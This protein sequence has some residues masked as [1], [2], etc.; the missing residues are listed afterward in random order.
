MRARDRS[1]RFWFSGARSVWVL[2]FALLLAAPSCG[3]S[4][5]ADTVTYDSSTKQENL[6]AQPTSSENSPAERAA[7]DWSGGSPTTT[8]ASSLFSD[9]YSGEWLASPADYSFPG[10]DGQSLTVYSGRN[11]S[12]IG[13]LLKLFE[14]V[15]GVDVSVRYGNSTDLAL[16][17]EAEGEASP[18]DLFISQ[19]PG[20]IEYLAARGSLTRL[21]DDL[22]ELVPSGMRSADGYWVGL[23]GRR[24]VLVYNTWLVSEE[25]LPES[26]F[27][28]TDPLYKKRVAV[29]PAN[30]SFQDFITLMRSSVG[31]ERALAWLEGMAKN[32]S[33]VYAK[34]S[35]IVDGVLR[36]EVDMGLVNHYYLLRYLDE[37]PGA[38]GANYYFPDDDL[39][40]TMLLTGV[41][42]LREI[43]EVSSAKRALLEF[44]L[45]DGSQGYYYANTREYPAREG[46]RRPSIL[47]PLPEQ[48][49]AFR[50]SELAEG[51]TGTLR[52]IELS[53]IG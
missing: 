39:G 30:S 26:V 40:S 24:R 29:A 18:A 37:E 34:N 13:P 36:G 22:L 2:T 15:S 42:A 46:Y 9:P 8:A 47:P 53:G 14:D 52:L 51:L 3:D 32:S 38:P 7:E 33:P 16:L 5:V 44:L 27:E 23:S 49:Q 12:L 6:D 48:V 41:G 19:S 17:I 50:F 35:A 10:L 25:E 21:P 1:R 20:A 11:E 45:S 4:E 43:G 28:L 31:D